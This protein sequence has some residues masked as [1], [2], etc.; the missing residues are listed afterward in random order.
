VIA[1]ELLLRH[2]EC[3]LVIDARGGDDVR[4]ARLE[5]L[6]GDDPDAATR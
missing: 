1:P 3:D 6:D 2:G 4:A 5:E